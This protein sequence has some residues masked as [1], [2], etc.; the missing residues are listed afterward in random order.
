LNWHLSIFDAGA[1]ATMKI[2][3][4]SVISGLK[5]CEVDIS[6]VTGTDWHIELW[7]WLSIHQGHKYQ[8]TF[9]AKASSSKV[10]TVAVQEESSPYTMYLGKQHT[11]STV[12]Q[13]FTDTVSINNEDQAK[14]EFF[15]GNTTVPVWIDAVSVV[16]TSSIMTGLPEIGG[17]KSEAITL[18]NN[19]PN[20]FN[21]STTIEY[22][23][24]EYGLVTLKVFDTMGREVKTLVNEQKPMGKYLVE[25]NASAL[26]TGTYFCKMQNGTKSEVK[27][28]LLL[29]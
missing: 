4:S 29:R 6:Q 2:D 18:V 28:M 16:E 19:Y 3:S 25:W 9:K 12:V 8:I 26:P 5:S 23:V 1:S 22:K 7:Q 17:E 21:T 27:K 11:L 14:L 24:I 13:T 10:I 20:P 15:L